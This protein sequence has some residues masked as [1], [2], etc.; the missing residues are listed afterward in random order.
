MKDPDCDQSGTTGSEQNITWFPEQAELTTYSIPG[1]RKE[2]NSD[3]SG[4]Q[5]QYHMSE[6]FSETGIKKKP[7]KKL[8][9]SH[10]VK[11]SLFKCHDKSVHM[12]MRIPETA[13]QMKPRKRCSECWKMKKRS[14]TYWQ[15]S[16]CNVGLHLNCF[17]KYHILM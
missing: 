4:G 11:Y 7:R 13:C 15:C 6:I 12:P 2:N 10:Y 8:R 14:E 17:E 1:L 3:K 9:S 16:V 5:L